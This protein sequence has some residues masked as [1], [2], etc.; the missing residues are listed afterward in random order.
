MSFSFT[1]LLNTKTLY[2]AVVDDSST[3][4]VPTGTLQASSGEVGGIQLVANGSLTARCHSIL[5][6]AALKQW[7]GRNMTIS[8]V[9]LDRSGQN[10]LGRRER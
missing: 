4:E 3:L 6:I 5:H 8:R 7:D 2:K 1:D 9:G 10:I